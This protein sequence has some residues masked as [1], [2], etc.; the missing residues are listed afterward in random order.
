MSSSSRTDTQKNDKA[1]QKPRV[2]KTNNSL[3]LIDV[4]KEPKA[5][6]RKDVLTRVKDGLDRKTQKTKR[7]EVKKSIKD[8]NDQ[9]ESVN[10]KAEDWK[11]GYLKAQAVRD[12]ARR[13]GRK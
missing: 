10:K 12:E 6:Q 3:A 2:Y 1:T 11:D 8:L 4:T 7:D 13:A 5:I 9:I